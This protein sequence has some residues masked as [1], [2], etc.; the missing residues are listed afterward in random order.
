MAEARFLKDCPD[1][2]VAL[3]IGQGVGKGNASVQISIFVFGQPGIRVGD[4]YDKVATLGF[5]GHEILKMV[6]MENLKPTVNDSRGHHQFDPKTRKS[7]MFCFFTLLI[8]NTQGLI[9]GEI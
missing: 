9:Q 5:A 6:V 2:G 7:K 3:K 8:L 1:H 4:A